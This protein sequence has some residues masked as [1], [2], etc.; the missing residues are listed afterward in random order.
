MTLPAV[1]KHIRVLERAGLTV[2]E[3][4]GRERRCQ[5]AAI[6]LGEAV[7]WLERYRVFW[8]ASFDRLAAFLETETDEKEG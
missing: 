1:S 2:I 8:E 4:R 5:L 7:D 6:P 3:R